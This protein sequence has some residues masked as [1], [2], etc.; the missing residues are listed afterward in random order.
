VVVGCLD[1]PAAQGRA[2]QA[3]FNH[4]N[5]PRNTPT[6]ERLRT[7]HEKHPLINCVSAQL[8]GSS[9]LWSGQEFFSRDVC[10]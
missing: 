3:D 8:E 7:Y 4:K 5:G 10:R 2:L 6:H 1:L 9:K